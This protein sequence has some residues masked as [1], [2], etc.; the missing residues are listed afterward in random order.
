MRDLNPTLNRPQEEFRAM[1]EKF[2]AMVTGFGGGKTWGGGANL[3]EHA[4][5]FPG[6]PMGYFAPT[7]P[8]I[9]DIFYPTIEEVADD[10]G[11]STKIM[12]SAKEVRLYEGA[13]LR[14]TIMCRSMDSPDTIIGFKIG[15]AQVDEIDTMTMDKA[16]RAWRKIIARMRHKG[17]DNRVDVTTTPEGYRFVYNQ[18]V[19]LPSTSPEMAK[20]YG[21]VHAS[22]YDNEA[23]L[24]EGYIDSLLASYPRQLI[25]AYINGQF[26]NLQSGSVYPEFSRRLNSCDT[27]RKPGANGQ[28]GEPLHVGIDFNVLNM[29]AIVTV[30]RNGEPH[31]VDELTGVRDTP[32]MARILHE[33]YRLNDKHTITVYPDASGQNTSSKNAAES[34]LT[35]L[36]QNGFLLRV[37]TTNPAIRDRVNC[38]NALI[39]NG[40]GHR[41]LKVNTLMCPTLTESLEQQAYDKNAQPDKTTGHDHCN[42]AIGYRLMQDWPLE[43]PFT[44]V[45]PMFA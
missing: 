11:L 5:Q 16:M 21:V 1:T 36:R 27:V 18:F 6:V 39:L 20:L 15:H 34:D 32:T 25:E 24:P 22:T 33:R 38:V 4:Y 31:V 30:T 8:M 3:C 44:V 23:N 29:T 45:R 10:W 19:K 13:T 7:Y 28:P 12:T 43:R 9:R 40:K 26:V 37:D 35:I 14:S 42:D 2:R 41:R 17:G